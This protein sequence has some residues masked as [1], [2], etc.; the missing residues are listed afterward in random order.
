ML[1]AIWKYIFTKYEKPPTAKTLQEAHRRLECL[2]IQRVRHCKDDFQ[3]EAIIEAYRIGRNSSDM[4][5]INR[6]MSELKKL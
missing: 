1:V 2:Y 6:S 3:L 5:T 4:E